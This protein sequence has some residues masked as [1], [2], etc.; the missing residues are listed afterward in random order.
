MASNIPVPCFSG[1]IAENFHL[2]EFKLKSWL[3]LS[4]C[5]EE[6]KKDVLILTLKGA[7]LAWYEKLSPEKRKD[8]EQSMAALEK[9][10]GN[11]TRLK[12]ERKSAGNKIGLRRFRD[13]RHRDEMVE[14]SSGRAR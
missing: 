9:R 11:K 6:D 12:M 3:R 4:D 7:A 13:E 14:V 8:F 2:F 5:Q 10:F 1:H